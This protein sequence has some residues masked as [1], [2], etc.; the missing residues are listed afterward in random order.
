MDSNYLQ[1]Y[2]PVLFTT[3]RPPA[4]NKEEIKKKVSSPMTFRDPGERNEATQ[5]RH[6]NNA[7]TQAE[8]THHAAAQ[9]GPT[10]KAATQAEPTHL[11]SNLTS[12]SNATYRTVSKKSTGTLKEQ[13]QWWFHKTQRSRL[14]KTGDSPEWFHGFITRRRAEEMLQGAPLGTFLVR[15]C[16]SRVGFVLSYRGTE[17]CR[18][19]MVAQLPDNHYVIEG[20]TM[21]HRELQDLLGHYC[22]HPLD[23]Y[24]E[25]LTTACTKKPKI[26]VS[27]GTEAA[28]E[29][30]T[31]NKIQKEVSAQGE[32][33][34]ALSPKDRKDF[35][36]EGKL[37]GPYS[38]QGR[39]T[40][41]SS[42]SE[43]ESTNGLVLG[44][45]VAPYGLSKNISDAGLASKTKVSTK[46]QKYTTIEE[47]HTYADPTTCH[48]QETITVNEELD[49]PIAFYA[50][51]RG[52]VLEN[53][54][55]EVDTKRVA[56]D[57][58]QANTYRQAVAAT[59]P[60]TMAATLPHLQNRVPTLHSSFLV[61]KKPTSPTDTAFMT[62]GSSSKPLC[63]SKTS[64]QRAK[65]QFDDPT[66]GNNA[67]HQGNQGASNTVEDLENIYEKIPENR[68]FRSRKSWSAKHKPS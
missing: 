23:P 46:D 59:L 56:P 18:H 40:K 27:D 49:E 55:S 2:P 16:E 12:S 58:V 1:D 20:E 63:N 44:D 13:T 64:Q 61:H 14:M 30:Q 28:K 4:V 26:P 66:Y 19:F 35:T 17:R 29:R 10:N 7:M 57:G 9:A 32:A 52:S 15:F 60:Q 34:P 47:L 31:Q 5:A 68:S 37:Q 36:Y 50:V 42:P 6:T 21:A 3:F 65:S 11:P 67:M 48:K 22:R 43:I 39:L 53:V 51:G 33:A 45:H 54:Y 24:K 41:Q 62:W 25:M 8:P 38:L